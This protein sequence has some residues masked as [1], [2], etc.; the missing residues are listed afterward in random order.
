MLDN[1]V[2]PSQRTDALPTAPGPPVLMWFF[3]HA[4]FEAFLAVEG[5]F[6]E[7]IENF[8][9]SILPRADADFFNDPLESGVANLP[10]EYPFPDGMTG[11]PNLRVQSNVDGGNPTFPNF[12]GV[13][14]L[15]AVSLGVVGTVSDI[16]IAYEIEHSL[17]LI[18]LGDGKSAVGFNPVTLF[19]GGDVE[20]KV[21]NTANDFLGM[22][23]VPA[24]YTGADFLAVWSSDP[25]GRINIFD[26]SSGGGGFNPDGGLEGFD[27]IETWEATPPV[28]LIWFNNQSDFEIFNHGD[29]KVSKGTEDFEESFLGPD[30]RFIFNDPLEFDVPNLPDGLPFPFGMTGLPNLIVQSN[31][32]GGDPFVQ[33]PIG[34]NGLMAV[35]AGFLGVVSDVVLSS[36]FKHYEFHS[37][38]L[39]FTEEKSGV[40]FNTITLGTE[41]VEVRVYSW[42]NVFLGMMTSPADPTGANFIGVWSSIPIGRI[43]IFSPDTTVEGGDNIQAWEVGSV[44]F[45]LDADQFELALSKRDKELKGFEDFSE[46]VLGPNNIDFIDDPLDANTSDP[47]SFPKGILIDN[48]TFQ[49]NVGGADSSEPNPQGAN[50]LVLLTIDALGVT[51]DTVLAGGA[52]DAFDI[53][54]GPPDGEPG[55]QHTALGLNLITFGNSGNVTVTVYDENNNFLGRIEDVP[56][57]VV[58]GGFLGMM[59]PQGLKIGRVNIWNPDGLGEGVY[60]VA[61]YFVDLTLACPWDLNRSGIVDTS[62]LLS[63]LAS[64]GP[65]NGCPADFDDDGLIGHLDLIMLI[66]HW[67]FCPL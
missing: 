13:D 12:S 15:V 31:V 28:G 44:D 5:M 46:N 52:A 7:G 42:T 23:T 26:I 30:S 16:V 2:S 64:W 34:P 41:S 59:V 66:A 4:D 24:E 35:S 8:E 51:S 55:E 63:L 22:Q 32:L 6:L 67:G 65:C 40:G 45:F 25:I 48:L 53:L 60:D 17:D 56:A 27:N 39:I 36:F 43:N 3:N 50:G 21:Y 10:D 54:S 11:L 18:L 20:V 37:L 14:G 61:A 33:A 29:G 57:P 58:D 62:D 38:D 49:S 1:K 47:D 19:G 9:E